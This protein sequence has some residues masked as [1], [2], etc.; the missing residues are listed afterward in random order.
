MSNYE[1]KC[2]VG[3]DLGGTKMLSQIFDSKFYSLGR[4]R[5]KTRGHEGSDV[6]LG[7]IADLIRSSMKDVNLKN[8]DLGGIG[9]GAPGPLDLQ[10]GI[11]KS[12]PNLGWKDV[13]L[14]EFLK[15]TF[16]CPVLVIND[17]DAGVFGEYSFG[18][19]RGSRCCLGVFPGTGIGGGCVY[20]GEIFFGN[21]TSCFE[22]GHMQIAA[23]GPL[24]GCGRRGCLEAVASRLAISASAAQAAYRGDAP[25]LRADAGTDLSNIRSKALARAIDAGDDAVR[26]II[27]NA[28]RSIGVAIG[29]LVNLL[30]PDKIILGGGLVE[31]MPNIFVETVAGTA[32]KRV[33]PAFEDSFAVVAAQLG[34]DSAAMGAAAWIH[35][36]VAGP[37]SDES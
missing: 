8:S 27:R 31:A 7:R 17:V 16:G 22:V 13:H 9:I 26:E 35:Q 10:R 30:L 19:G 25:N 18:A 6:G 4:R 14:G 2:W 20:N 28:A 34:D 12:A 32:R 5:E 33:L 15:E 29:N 3:F 11:I 37:I 23:D 21:N 24:C 1:E 36:N